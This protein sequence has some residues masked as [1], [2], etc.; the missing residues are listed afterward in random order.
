M[1]PPQSVIKL[2][3]TLRALQAKGMAIL[4]ITHKLEEIN[5]LCDTATIL[6]SG[7]VTG[8][9]DPRSTVRQDLATMM[10]GRPMPPPLHPT[11]HGLGDIRLEVKGLDY[12]NDDPFG[13]S[14]RDVSVA[15]KGGEIVGIAGISG[16]GQQELAALSR[17]SCCN[18]PPNATRSASWARRL[19]TVASAERRQLGFAFVPEERLGRGAVPE[20]SLSRQCA[21]DR[22]WIRIGKA[23]L[24]LAR[25]AS[26]PSRKNAFPV[27]MSARPARKPK[28]ELCQAAIC[29]NSSWAAR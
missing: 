21:S 2:F 6:R 20:M 9:V 26:A 16:N 10:I 22:A 14:L 8:R 1:L 19:E 28:P 23:W 25:V 7:R 24:H 27:L 3:E 29:K 11:P 12:L 17:A 13:I 5:E 4:F 18:R 15:V